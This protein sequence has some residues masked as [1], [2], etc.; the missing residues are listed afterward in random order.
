M[1]AV[2][3]E[4][5]FELLDV[6][7]TFSVVFGTEDTGY[8]TLS[9]P[10]LTAGEVRAGDV[11]M[12]QE[13]S[14]AFGRDYRGSKAYAFEVGVLTDHLAGA[15]TALRANLNYL[16]ALE[17]AWTD[18]RWRRN[19]WALA[20]LRVCEGGQTWRCYGRPRRY[21]EVVG[22]L[23]DDGFTPVVMDFQL[24]DNSFYSD[25][26]YSVGVPIA[27]AGAAPGLVAPLSALI[28][29]I[30]PTVGSGTMVVG[31]TKATWPVVQFTGP[32]IEPSVTIGDLHIGLTGTLATN[33]V[34]VYDPRPWMRTCYR[35]SDGQ[36]LGGRID[37]ATPPMRDV[38]LRP[39]TYAVE[40]A[41]KDQ[42]GWSGGAVAWR[43]ARS[44]P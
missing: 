14:T 17:N 38:S 37:R 43:D 12:S 32:C 30:Q 27:A 9:R 22:N 11:D 18:E 35:P 4:H 16:D 5:Q 31:G 7:G 1:P 28:T 21:D 29:T 33:E 25:V 44:R 39:G 19:P 36:G 15:D 8:L 20:M 24:R 13:D 23:T 3:R 34:V 10:V 40:F 41:A 2:L 6:E 42:T 26:L